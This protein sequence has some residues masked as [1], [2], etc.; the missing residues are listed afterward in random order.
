MNGILARIGAPTIAVA[1]LCSCAGLFDHNGERSQVG[2]ISSY[3]EPVVIEVPDTVAQG[4][5]FSVGV[6]PYG[7]GCVSVGRTLVTVSGLQAVATPYDTRSGEDLCPDI[8]RELDHRTTI[9][10][11]QPGT[12][13]V[14]F[15]ALRE[16]EDTI[17]TEVR[18]VHVR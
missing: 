3:G 12:G 7:N 2:T 1:P 8:L 9:T 15:R 18:V 16:P 14:R 6:R 13:V 10:C 4:Q 11:D 5:P 17:T